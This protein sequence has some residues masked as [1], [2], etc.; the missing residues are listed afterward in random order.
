M[1]RSHLVVLLACLAGSPTPAL[2]QSREP[3]RVFFDWG[4][5]E[6]SRDAEATLN[7]AVT[8]YVRLKP[9]HV[10]VGGH[11]D[12]SGPVG[13]NLTASRRRAKA[14]ESYL[15]DHGIPADAISISAFGEGRP[16]VA[17][18]DGVR[19][20]QNRRVEISFVP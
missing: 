9:N 1:R 6:L 17:T 12:R 5:P 10:M 13:V 14:V 19:E 15:V 18:A 3:F 2:A 20:A 11:T 16:I 4:E 7:E 8:D